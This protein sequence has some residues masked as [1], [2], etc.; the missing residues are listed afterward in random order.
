VGKLGELWNLP[1]EANGQKLGR[2]NITRN[3]DSLPGNSA[4][5]MTSKRVGVRGVS[6]LTF[7]DSK[8]LTPVQPSWLEKP[9]GERNSRT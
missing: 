1:A 4:L 3:A 8:H 5:M 2:K 9:P 6:F 7:E